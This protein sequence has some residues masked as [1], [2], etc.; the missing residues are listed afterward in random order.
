MTNGLSFY[1]LLNT[2]NVNYSSLNLGCVI[3]DLILIL[4]N[5]VNSNRQAL[6]SSKCNDYSKSYF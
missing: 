2:L 4:A 3:N 1:D 5:G 6:R